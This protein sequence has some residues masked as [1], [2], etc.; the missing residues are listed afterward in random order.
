MQAVYFVQ[1]TRNKMVE[2]RFPQGRGV[3]VPGFWGEGKGNKAKKGDCGTRIESA[4]PL[5][6]VHTLI[7]RRSGEI[8]CKDLQSRRACFA[9]EGSGLPGPQMRGT[10]GTRDSR[11]M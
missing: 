9:H 10:R 8:I 4:R 6:L 1:V 5:D 11:P 3:G 7:V 2:K